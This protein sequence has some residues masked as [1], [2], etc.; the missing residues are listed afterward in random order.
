MLTQ[1]LFKLEH[2]TRQ[3]ECMIERHMPEFEEAYEEFANEDITDLVKGTEFAIKDVEDSDDSDDKI[4]VV[5]EPEPDD[6]DVELPA[7]SLTTRVMNDW[8]RRR[9]KFSHDYARVG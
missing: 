8:T 3:T 4:G 1:S 6:T 7:I 5:N 2:Y 9:D